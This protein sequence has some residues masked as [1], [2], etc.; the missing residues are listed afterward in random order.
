MAE[1]TAS[2]MEVTG[3][4]H[5]TAERMMQAAGSDLDSAIS[6]FYEAEAGD[7]DV[8]AGEADGG[9]DTAPALPALPQE[10]L[11]ADILSN[12]RKETEPVEPSSWAGRGRT[13]DS[14]AAAADASDEA[15]APDPDAR[16]NAKRVRIIFWADGFTV[17]DL[18]AEEAAAAAAAKPAA[19]QARKTGIA[20]LGDH[21]KAAA[22]SPQAKMPDL[23]KYED[24]REF[25]ED[26]KN[27]MP[28]SEFREIDLSSGIPVR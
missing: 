27:G 3:A 25:M 11:V 2:F 5:A 22:A 9:D 6:L 24:N 15:P 10:S 26:L 7:A 20:T 19:P 13:L 12:A 14:A 8:D 21:R 18:N 28:P 17:E 23:R 4:D 16:H 1:G